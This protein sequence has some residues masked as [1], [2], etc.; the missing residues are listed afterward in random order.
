MN[1]IQKIANRIEGRIETQVN[2]QFARTGKRTGQKVKDQWNLDLW[3][4]A[5]AGIDAL[6]G[7]AGENTKWVMRVLTMIIWPRGYSETQKLARDG[8]DADRLAEVEAEKEADI[9]RVFQIEETK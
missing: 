9:N 1:I 5:A 2:E 7:E 4:G 6:E 3:C 8:R